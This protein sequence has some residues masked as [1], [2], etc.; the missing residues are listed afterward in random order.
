LSRGMEL[1]RSALYGYRGRKGHVLT[2]LE[3][4]TLIE[5]RIFPKERG[6]GGKITKVR[7][8]YDNA[9]IK[10]FIQRITHEGSSAVPG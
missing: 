1:P 7:I 6:R 10:K 2:E 3:R 5:I 9:L 4:Q 8:A